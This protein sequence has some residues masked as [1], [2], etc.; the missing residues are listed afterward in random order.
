[1]KPNTFT[2]WT[3]HRLLFLC[4]VFPEQAAKDRDNEGRVTVMMGGA[5][6][7][8]VKD[9][10]TDELEQLAITKVCLSSHGYMLSGLCGGGKGL[11]LL[12]VGCDCAC[13]G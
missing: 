9:M 5:H 2:L 13:C 12:V 7:P 11:G 10:S 3:P 4:S 1:M 6:S 8:G